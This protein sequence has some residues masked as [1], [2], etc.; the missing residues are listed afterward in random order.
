VIGLTHKDKL[1]KNKIK[2]KKEEEEKKTLLI[3]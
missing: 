3:I 2:N 1:N